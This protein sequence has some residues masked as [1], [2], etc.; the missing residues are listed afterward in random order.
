MVQRTW[1]LPCEGRDR[2][3]DSDH[4]CQMPSKIQSRC[5]QCG[6]ENRTKVVRHEPFDPDE[7]T[8]V[9]PCDTCDERTVQNQLGM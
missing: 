4:A 9:L 3:F 2:R 5:T 8:Q 1:T 6:N 7:K